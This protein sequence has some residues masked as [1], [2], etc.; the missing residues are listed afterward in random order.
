MISPEG[1][2]IQHAFKFLFPVTNNVAEYEALVEGVNLAVELEVQVLD[3]F[4]DS[5]LVVKQLNREFK[6]HND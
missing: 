3:I 2:K 5:Q 6:A 4:A 1:F